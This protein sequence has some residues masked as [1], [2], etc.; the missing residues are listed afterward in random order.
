MVLHSVVN[1]VFAYFSDKS[2]VVRPLEVGLSMLPTTITRIKQIHKKYLKMY[3][4]KNYL[5]STVL[6]TEKNSQSNVLCTEKENINF[7]G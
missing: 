2:D 5:P 3:L 1:L 6:Y 4:A 7:S